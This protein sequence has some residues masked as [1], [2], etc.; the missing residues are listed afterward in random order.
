MS[1]L[2]INTDDS[3]CEISTGKNWMNTIKKDSG[4]N[5]INLLF[6]WYLCDNYKLF[7]YGSIRGNQINNHVLPSNGVSSIDINLSNNFILYDN[8]YFV[9]LCNNNIV[10][11]KI[12]EYGEFY[13]VNYDSSSEDYNELEDDEYINNSSLNKKYNYVPVDYMNNLSYDNNIY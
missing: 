11:Y 9:K 4:N 5:D 12:K 10:K 2:R 6:E 3:M 1:I 8:I 13:S 7:L